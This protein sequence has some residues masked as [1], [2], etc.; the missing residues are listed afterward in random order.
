MEFR[1]NRTIAAAFAAATL[2]ASPCASASEWT[3]LDFQTR[4]CRP[5]S[6]VGLSNPDT[7]ITFLR[8]RGAF[9]DVHVK[10]DAD[11]AFR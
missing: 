8:A 5:G 7:L 9:K 1:M 6:Y 10:R 11:C 4:H 2:L 3:V